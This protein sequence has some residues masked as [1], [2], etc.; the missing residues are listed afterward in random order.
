MARPRN[1]DVLVVGG[2]PVG[3]V[4]ALALAQKGIE[5]TVIDQEDRTAVHGYALALH[6]RS[7]AKLAHLEVAEELV[8]AGQRI[9]SIAY[10]SKNERMASVD[11][12]T[13]DV[14]LP[15]VLALPQSKLEDVLSARLKA[16]GIKVIS[17][18]RLARFDV[19]ADCVVATVD[20][21]D[22]VP[23]GYPVA[24]SNQLV[25]GQSI[26]NTKFV[27]GADGHH[28][29]IRR[30][31]GISFKKASAASL[32]AVFEFLGEPEAPHEMRVQLT[33]EGASGLWPLP[34]GRCRASFELGDPALFEPR[35]SEQR[36]VR[37]VGPAVFPQLDEARLGDLVVKRAPWFSAPIGEVLW[38]IGVCFE[39]WVASEMGEGRVWIAGDAAHVLLPLGMQSMN[40]GIIEAVEL[41][42]AINTSLKEGGAANSLTLYGQ[43][44]LT[45]S[46]QLVRP[47]SAFEARANADL[48]V[49]TNLA[50]IIS[51]LPA[52]DSELTSLVDQLGCERLP[53]QIGDLT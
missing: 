38:S 39:R 31:L 52:T 40:L 35:R 15:F 9:D 27:V 23:G 47:Q 34:E 45:E 29:L 37:Q 13:L 6:S 17:N 25:V 36:V 11:L 44:R 4:A 10:Y 48:W 3:L 12:R 30:Q 22:R 14:A 26:F 18:R 43:K 49:Q 32:F 21:L 46:R 16:L 42:E 50:S 19:E 51:T 33:G 53:T 28:S 8:A 1:T 20:H 41:T 2:G 5:V 24:T 7:L